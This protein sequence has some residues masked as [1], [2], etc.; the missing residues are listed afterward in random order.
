[1]H[2]ILIAAVFTVF[3][4]SPAISKNAADLKELHRLEAV[5]NNAHVK[6][7]A[8]ALDKLWSND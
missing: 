7:D 1:M 3:Q 8:D 2:S 5:W 4:G 6:G